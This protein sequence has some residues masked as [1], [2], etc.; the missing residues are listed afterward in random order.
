M[1]FRLVHDAKAAA[2]VCMPSTVCGDGDG[3]NVHAPANAGSAEVL[4][5]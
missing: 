5:E 4:L 3:C 1:R 2:D